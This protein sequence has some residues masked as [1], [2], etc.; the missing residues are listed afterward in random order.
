MTLVSD[1][2]IH[3][4][5]LRGKTFRRCDELQPTAGH[6]DTP[7]RTFVH[8]IVA[9]ADNQGRPF[10]TDNSSFD[11]HPHCATIKLG[12]RDLASGWALADAYARVTWMRSDEERNCAMSSGLW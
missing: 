8:A 1:Q 12:G 2:K 4:V 10:T 6:G 11:H 7:V 5:V 3:A 9:A